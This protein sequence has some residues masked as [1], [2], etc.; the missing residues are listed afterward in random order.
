MM[1]KEKRL[2]VKAIP[3]PVSNKHEPVPHDVL[4]EHEATYGII[5]PK[6]KK[7]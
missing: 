6:G 4:P 3:V 1:P 2:T 5:A 7:Y